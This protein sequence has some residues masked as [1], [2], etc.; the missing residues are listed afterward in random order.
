MELKACAIPLCP[1]FAQP[2]RQT[3]R[4]H[5]YAVQVP[6]VLGLAP[7]AACRRKLREGEWVFIKHAQVKTK[8]GSALLYTHVACDP[9]PRPSLKARRDAPKPLFEVLPPVV[10]DA[11]AAASGG[12]LVG[13]LC[14]TRPGVFPPTADAPWGSVASPTCIHIEHCGVRAILGP[15]RRLDDVT[16]E[17]E[18]TCTQCGAVTARRSIERETNSAIA[19]TP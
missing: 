4:I 8:D 16:V 10:P 13:P 6:S 7:C 3:C 18:V 11:P 19:S 1:A 15:P 17:H 5:A 2:G 14:A 12:P 9:T